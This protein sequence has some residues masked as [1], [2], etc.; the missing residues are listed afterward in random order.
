[1]SIA[2]QT[3]S[4][5]ITLVSS[6]A[7]VLVGC[8]P[9]GPGDDIP[10]QASYC[11]IDFEEDFP[12][13]REVELGFGPA[14]EFRPYQ[15]GEEIE[16]ITGGQGATMITPVV[17]V[18]MGAADELEPCFKVRV[19]QGLEFSSEWN[20]QFYQEGGSLFSDGALYFLTY[21]TGET[22]LDVTVQGKGFSGT[23]SVN[24]VLK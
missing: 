1:M 8:G 4:I 13:T 23:K 12:E 10:D 2:M 15:E 21:T 16:T 11:A 24:V 19:G 20:I 7:G 22:P 5:L 18:A 14:S 9:L 17:R 6:V 3:K